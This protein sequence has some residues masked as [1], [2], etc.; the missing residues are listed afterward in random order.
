MPHCG[1]PRPAIHA[2]CSVL[3]CWKSAVRTKPPFADAA[4]AIAENVRI[5]SVALFLILH[6]SPKR[7]FKSADPAGLQTAFRRGRLQQS[8]R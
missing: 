2:S 8:R 5:R 1:F 4:F 3:D 6:I 7:S